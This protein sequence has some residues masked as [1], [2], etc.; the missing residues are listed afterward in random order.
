MSCYEAG[1]DG[2]WLNRALLESG[3]EK[4]VVDSSSIEVNRRAR[5]AKIDGLD[6][7]KLVTMLVRYQL[8]EVKIWS[9]VQVPSPENEDGR[10]LHRELNALKK[11][12]TR[13]TNRI[14]ALLIRQ[15]I[16]LTPRTQLSQKTCEEMRAAYCTF[17]TGC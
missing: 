14:K 2:F 3:V 11:E 5:R 13:A 15:G 1:C 8:G 17:T 7:R 10:P 9:V 6:V 12:S 16:R 4:I